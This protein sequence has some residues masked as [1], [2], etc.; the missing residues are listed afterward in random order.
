MTH[1]EDYFAGCSFNK[2]NELDFDVLHRIFKRIL[3]GS[4]NTAI[5]ITCK[6]D[7]VTL[8]LFPVL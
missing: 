5:S 4:I 1:I 8:N 6:N 3:E 7:W 2:D